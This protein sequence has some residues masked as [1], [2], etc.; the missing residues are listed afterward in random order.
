MLHLLITCAI[1]IVLVNHKDEFNELKTE[2]TQFEQQIKLLEKSLT[3]LTETVD[4][5]EIQAGR[6]TN[7]ANDHTAVLLGLPYSSHENTRNLVTRVLDCLGVENSSC[8]IRSVSR[9]YENKKLLQP[10][11]PIRITFQDLKAKDQ[12]FMKKR[13]YGK[14]LSTSV[15]PHLMRNGKTTTIILRDE[16]NPLALELLKQ[17]REYQK[18]M[19]VKYVWSGR[20]GT[21][22][23]RKDDNEKPIAVRTR[24]D[25]E[26]IRL[27]LHS[28]DTV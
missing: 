10:L 25:L 21:V 13:E 16:L 12:V 24:N 18:E 23:M 19:N 4:K 20:G 17:A 3:T 26:R 7:S 6:Y 8:S 1:T 9:V 27:L 14:L 5:L 2:N 22:W 28:Q 15:D 11:I